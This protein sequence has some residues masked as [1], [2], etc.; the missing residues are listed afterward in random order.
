MAHGTKQLEA[1]QPQIH[2]ASGGKPEAEIAPSLEDLRGKPYQRQTK[3][4]RAV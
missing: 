2:S 4:L 1:K 3:A